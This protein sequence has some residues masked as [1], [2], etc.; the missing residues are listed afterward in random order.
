MLWA[1]MIQIIGTKKSSETRKAER[2]FKERGVKYHFVDL[3]ERGLS[4]GE[5]ENISRSIS[6]S[7]LIDTGSKEYKSRGM[8]YM[9]FDIAEELLEHPALLKIPIVR[10]NKEAVIG[11]QEETWKQW[12]QKEKE[13]A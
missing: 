7:E 5:L 8:E 13:E 10:R 4:P 1:I 3:K 12:V 9:E 2:F 11:M 6:P